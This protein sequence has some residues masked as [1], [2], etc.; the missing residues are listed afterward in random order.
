MTEEKEGEHKSEDDIIE[1][2][3]FSEG[4]CPET[5]TL[6]FKGQRATDIRSNSRVKMPGPRSNKKETEFQTRLTFGY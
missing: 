1:E 4:Y 3:R 2:N 6:K 5:K